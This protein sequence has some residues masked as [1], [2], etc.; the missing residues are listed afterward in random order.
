MEIGDRVKVVRIDDY[1]RSVFECN[2][3]PLPI[4]M[5]GT[6][7]EMY[8]NHAMHQTQVVVNIAG[9]GYIYEPWEL[10]LVAER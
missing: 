6:I 5:V 4:G 7:E 8:Y 10:A 3:T 2:K 1:T 9:V